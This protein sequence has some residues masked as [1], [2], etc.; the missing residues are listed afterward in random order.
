MEKSKEA[1]SVTHK[2]TEIVHQIDILTEENT[3]LSLD[4]GN[5]QIQLSEY[6]SIVNQKEEEELA[7]NLASKERFI[8]G[9]LKKYNSVLNLTE[10]QQYKIGE[11]EWKHNEYWKNYPKSKAGKRPPSPLIKIKSILSDE[12]YKAWKTHQ[13]Q[14]KN[15][16]AE[17]NATLVL[18]KYP[19]SMNLTEEQKDFIFQNLFKSEH[20]ATKGK[21]L[22]KL[23]DSKYKEFGRNG[24]TMMIASEKVLTEEQMEILIQSL[25]N[26]KL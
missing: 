7:H 3:K 1:E 18:G 22:K 4:V 13:N 21:Y 12:Q 25:T 16:T 14:Q 26:S 20:P 24:K 17:S 23:R 11:M 8:K 10:K 15:V 19:A 2:N 5:L 6:K 9:T